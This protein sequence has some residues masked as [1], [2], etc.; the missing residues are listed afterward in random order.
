MLNG[1]LISMLGARYL[2]KIIVA[3]IDTPF[4]YLGANWIGVAK[5]LERRHK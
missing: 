3:I 5:E 4:V 1:A 2:E